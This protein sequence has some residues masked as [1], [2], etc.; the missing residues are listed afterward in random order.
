MMQLL[1][2]MNRLLDR[3]PEAR[4][5]CLAFHTPIIVPVWPQVSL[6]KYWKCGLRIVQSMHKCELC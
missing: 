1:R 3:F 6:H 4:R 2:Q 5:R